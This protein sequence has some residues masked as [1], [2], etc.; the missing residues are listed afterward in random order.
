MLRGHQGTLLQCGQ[1][2]LQIG[3]PVVVRLSNTCAMLNG[4]QDGTSSR[5]RLHPA[6]IHPSASAQKLLIMPAACTQSMSS[7]CLCR[8]GHWLSKAQRSG[9][10]EGILHTYGSKTLSL[11]TS[12]MLPLQHMTFGELRPACMS[13]GQFLRCSC[14]A[15]AR[16]LAENACCIT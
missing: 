5:C 10:Y 12:A 8:D 9:L 2:L 4:M 11:A 1:V 15:H 13:A 6:A 7:T 14:H 16:Q 3:G